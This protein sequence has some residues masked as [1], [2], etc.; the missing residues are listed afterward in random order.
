MITDDDRLK[1]SELLS[2][3]HTT[4]DVFTILKEEFRVP[5]TY[6]IKLHHIDAAE[7]YL[8]ETLDIAAVTLRKIQALR[9]VATP[10]VETTTDVVVALAADLQ[11]ALDH[12][13]RHCANE[14]TADELTTFKHRVMLAARRAAG[15]GDIAV[16][17]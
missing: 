6:E 8:N 7:Q 15:K 12:L 1:P 14:N 17:K 16:L 5:D 11:R 3:Y 10:G 4:S 2:L 13:A 9:W